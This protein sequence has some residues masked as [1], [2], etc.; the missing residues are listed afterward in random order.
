MRSNNY[1][2]SSGAATRF[3]R[4]LFVQTWWMRCYRAYVAARVSRQY[5][6]GLARYLH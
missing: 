5:Q 1:D 6:N 2:A 3:S 4:P